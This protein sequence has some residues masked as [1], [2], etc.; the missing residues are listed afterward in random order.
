M[1][2]ALVVEDSPAVSELIVHVLSSDPAIEVVGTANDGEKALGA[3]ERLN[4]DI[5][6]M[7]IHMPKMNGLDAARRIMETHP[8]PI[9]VVSASYEPEEVSK[10]FRALEAGALAMVQ[11][12]AGAGHPD[13]Q[14]TSADL[15]DTVKAMSEVKVIRRWPR[16]SVPR[17]MH[18]VPPAGRNDLQPSLADVK[19]VAIGASTGGPMVLQ[20]I[21][22]NLPHNFHVPILVVQHIAPGFVRGFAD[23][24]G[25]SSNVTV[26]IANQGERMVSGQVY[27]AP[28][29]FQMRLGATGN[30]SLTTDEPENGLRPSVSCLFRSVA[31]AFGRQAI[32]VLLTGMGKDG[33]E[34]LRLM[35]EK[36]SI[37]IAQ[38]EESSV[39][40]GMPG[41][42]VRLGGASYVL[43]ADRI[44]AA[45][46]ALVH[47][48]EVAP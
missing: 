43:S 21:L 8:T 36:G 47:K 7:D 24:L 13:H 19:V 12:P 20:T 11:K 31:N 42:A 41:E 6:T 10:T 39:V 2:R 15:I 25:Q 40:Y 30:I 48:R 38:D 9:V 22:S 45:L 17:V 5:I 1:I 3:V 23:W 16:Y 14:E 46:T 35:K 29:G 37:T 28:D 34:E 4:P 44:A 33:A 32:G 27:L 18:T 26:G